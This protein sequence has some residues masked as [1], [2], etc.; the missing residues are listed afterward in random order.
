MNTNRPILLL[1]LCNLML[2]LHGCACFNDTLA[3]DIG[4]QLDLLKLE[5]AEG[6]SSREGWAPGNGFECNFDAEPWSRD[7]AHTA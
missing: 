2:A 3:V 6:S 7:D 4:G 1:A 5:L